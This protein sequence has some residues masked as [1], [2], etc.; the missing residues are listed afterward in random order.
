MI[1]DLAN[2]LGVCPQAST[3]PDIETYTGLAHTLFALED[4]YGF[5]IANN[6]DKERD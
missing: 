4:L 2:V 5:K 1:A 3:V 6:K